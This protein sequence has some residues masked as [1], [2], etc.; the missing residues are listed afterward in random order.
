MASGD[1][2]VLVED[3]CFE[4]PLATGDDY[5]VEVGVLM[6]PF[7]VEFVEME[8]NIGE[9]DAFGFQKERR[10]EDGESE[11]MRRESPCVRSVLLV[12]VDLLYLLCLRENAEEGLDV[13]TR[14][15][16]A[17]EG[18]PFVPH[19]VEK[20]VWIEPGE[21]AVARLPSPEKV[22]RIRASVFQAVL[23]FLDMPT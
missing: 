8:L 18:P 19:P 23:V 15:R 10:P 14:D 20:L 11:V 16:I 22:V 17:D 12:V 7:G 1:G 6:G 5:V 2:A 21:I 13:V 9:G 3:G 4:E